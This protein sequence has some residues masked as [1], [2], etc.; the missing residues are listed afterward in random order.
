M[1]LPFLMLALVSGQG[2][3][4]TAST[5]DPDKV[6]CKNI[7]ETGSRLRSKK[8]CMTRAQW[9][10]KQRVDQQELKRLQAGDGTRR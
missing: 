8:I 7:G 2:A 4:S 3:P 1:L 9:A 5:N 10:E 6:V